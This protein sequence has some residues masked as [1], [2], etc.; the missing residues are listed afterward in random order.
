MD[1][2]VTETEDEMMTRAF[3][4]AIVAALFATVAP[5]LLAGAETLAEIKRRGFFEACAH[6]DALPF[7]SQNSIPPGFQL[8]IAR[9]IAEDLGVGLRVDWIVYTRHA[10]VMNCD[11]LLGAIVKD[12]GTGP[13]GT[14]L[15]I[16]YAS[17]GWVLVLPKNSPPVIRFEDV[18]GDKGIGVQYASWV[19][20]SLD[21]RKLKTR[22][23]A[24][25]L[26]I[27]DAVS[28]GEIS[29]G[30]VVNIYAGW[31]L[32]LQPGSGVTLAEGYTP[33]PDLRW[34][35]ALGLR[36]ADAAL[37]DAVNGIL[38]RRLADGTI[39][40]IFARYGVPHLPPL[41]AQTPAKTTDAK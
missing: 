10:R 41:P 14:R 37:M 5:P 22:Q 8:D 30:A 17:S 34:N 31:Y 23:F 11:A 27:M 9:T 16:P 18:P 15:T 33:E 1:P 28:R 6:P 38:A 25:D 7:S 3:R 19:H 13:R 4:A 2:A 21:T 20:Y 35:V 32:H 36:A 12:D 39:A 24:N 40:A 29:A 26:E